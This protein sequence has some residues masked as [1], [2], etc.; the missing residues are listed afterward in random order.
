[1]TDRTFKLEILLPAPNEKENIEVKSGTKFA[2]LSS[3]YEK[4]Y[5]FRIIGAI[6]NNKLCDLGK[7]IQSD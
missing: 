5:N 3:T 1:M 7:E 6:F 2:D 4:Y